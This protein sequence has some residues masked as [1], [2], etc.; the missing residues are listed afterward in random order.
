[1]VFASDRSLKSESP[2][3]SWN[4]ELYRKSLTPGAK[5]VMIPTTQDYVK[6][7]F[8]WTPDGNFIAFVTS[9]SASDPRRQSDIML[10]SA[11]GK[12]GI[13][14]F[15]NEV[16][17]EWDPR[18]SSD[19][20][21][22]A[23]CS[24]QSG[25]NEIYVSRYPGPLNA[26]MV[27]YA[28]GHERS[29]GTG[30]RWAKDGRELFYLTLD[31]KLVVAELKLAGSGIQVVDRKVLFQTNAATNADNYDVS[32]DGSKIIINTVDEQGGPLVFVSNWAEGLKKK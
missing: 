32:P 27:S 22:I 18:F 30:P 2:Q 17:N 5:E 26:E 1:M 16:D 6:Q 21:W 14:P 4:Y 7:P 24:N 29:G 19:G 3:K 10:L 23:W 11:K 31:N 9:A 20:K 25:Q 28:G 15:L 8:D 12:G 13:T